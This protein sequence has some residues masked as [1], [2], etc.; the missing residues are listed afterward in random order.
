MNIRTAAL[1]DARAIAQVHVYSWQQAYRGLV[2]DSFLDRLSIDKREVAWQKSIARGTPE[3]WVA[4]LGQEIVGWVAFGPS[5]DEDTP[6]F[7][8]EVEA[9]YVLP[10]HWAN[11]IGRALWLVARRRLIDS[12]FTAVT[13][14][15]LA[16]NERAIRFYRAAGFS[17]GRCSERVFERN[18]KAL[19]EVRYEAVLG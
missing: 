9:I 8:E 11:G 19:R 10:T 18:G 14:W 3:L 6:P 15:V 13:L 1:S 4:E 7:T 17:S 2:P 5:R 12:K 16:E